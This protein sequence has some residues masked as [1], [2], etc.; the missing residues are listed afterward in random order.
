[1]IRVDI[2]PPD[3]LWSPSERTTWVTGNI[4]E[5]IPALAKQ[6]RAATGLRT[7]EVQAELV[8]ERVRQ[9]ALAD[10]RPAD[11]AN[12]WAMVAELDAG[13]PTDAHVVVGIGHFWYFVAPHLRPAT[14]RRFHFASGFALI[15]QALPVAVGAAAAI[16]DQRTVV[17]IEGDGSLPMN[18]QELQ[19]AVRHG[20]DL[21]LIVMNNQ[22]YGSEYHKLALADLDVAGSEFDSVPF[23]VVEISKAMGASARRARDPDQLRTALHEL[24]PLHGVRV[25]DA[26]ISRSTM[27]EVYERQHGHRS[28]D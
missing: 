25:I 17:A 12:P 15:G 10:G 8:A 11:G 2:R 28:S 22:A 1:V 4:H 16:G 5:V 13:L 18:V 21:L 9:D 14:D 26:E 23:D 24:L 20:V 6:A 3:E 19:A 7:A 27:S